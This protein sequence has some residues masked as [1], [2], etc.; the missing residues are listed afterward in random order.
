MR[1]TRENAREF[2]ARGN[3]KKA[4]LAAARLAI[5]PEPPRAAEPEPA[6]RDDEFSARKLARVREQIERL[7]AML[8][9]ATEP[10]AVD[11]LA[12]ALSRLYEIERLLAGR[13]LPGSLKPPS[14]RARAPSGPAPTYSVPACG[15]AHTTNSVSVA[16]KPSDNTTSAQPADSQAQAQGAFSHNI[17]ILQSDSPASQPGT[18]GPQGIYLPALPVPTVPNPTPGCA[19]PGVERDSRSLTKGQPALSPTPS[20]PAHF[21]SSSPVHHTVVTTAGVKPIVPSSPLPLQPQ[22]VTPPVKPDEYVT[23]KGPGGIPVRVKVQ[24]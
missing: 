19:A 13:P 3:A 16:Q 1:F 6:P 12:S 22:P 23:L 21:H 15:P 8:L 7:D 24:K 17:A 4:E 10:Q 2:A 14:V 20:T 5:P 18:P 9:E 11:R